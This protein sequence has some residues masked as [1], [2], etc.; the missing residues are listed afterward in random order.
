MRNST[1]FFWG[2]VL[3]LVGLLL[4][5]DTTGIFANWNINVW[6]LIGTYWPLILIFFGIRLL[7]TD[8]IT[9]SAILLLLGG[10]F[11]ATNLFNWNFFSI[12]WPLVIIVVGL[13]ILFRRES[14]S[15]N[16]GATYS[17]ADMINETVVFW[18]VDKKVTSKNFKGG[19]INVA[20]GGVKLDL[21]DAKISKDGAK[22][23]INAA[24]GGAEVFV[25]KDCRVITNGTG[26][27]GG[28]SPDIKPNK[29]T[30]PVLEITGVA[31][32]GGVDIKE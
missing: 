1:K 31:A 15:L 21:R 12:L 24:F 27:L 26:I 14:P 8:N 19:E 4:L 30:E 5:V 32:F 6:S 3:V 13:S 10:V 2:V 22:L 28:W 18:G 20:F 9:G 29:I 23:H 11:L 7:F 16:S 25:P 17:E